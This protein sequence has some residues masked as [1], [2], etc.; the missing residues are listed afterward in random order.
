MNYGKG[1]AI[2]EFAIVLPLFLL[3]LLG[4][5]FLFIYCYNLITLQNMSRDIARAMSV[6]TTYSTI[7]SNYSSGIMSNLMTRGYYIWDPADT[8]Y[9][10]EP[11]VNGND[12]TVTLTAKS[13]GSYSVLPDT[14]SA[15]TSMYKES[16]T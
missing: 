10:P 5:F 3:F 1:Q 2:T 13:D 11:T 8:A 7:Q 12:V 14:I 4:I 6:G 15:S 9:F 16:T